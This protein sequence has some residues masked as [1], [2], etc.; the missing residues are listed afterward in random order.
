MTITDVPIFATSTIPL[1]Q[2]FYSAESNKIDAAAHTHDNNYGVLLLT[3]DTHTTNSTYT[4]F[5]S[6][7]TNILKIVRQSQ[8]HYT[9]TTL[10]R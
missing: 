5:T 10:I 9:H 4:S 2:F 6:N 7:T 1:G 3:I 8:S